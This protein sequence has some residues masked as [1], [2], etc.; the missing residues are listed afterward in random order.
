MFNKVLVANRGEI[1]L[2][3]IRSCKKLGIRSVAVYSEADARSLHVK[4]ADEAYLLGPSEAKD[5]YLN[6]AKIIEIA[7]AHQVAA[8]HPGYGFLAE[9]A[10]FA[11]ACKSAG[12][13][14][15]GP[16]PETIRLMGDKLQAKKLAHELK[17]RLVPGIT[18]ESAGMEIATSQAKLKSFAQEAGYPLILKAA[19]GGGGRGMR[20]IFNEAD[21]EHSLL[22]ASREA[23]AFFSDGRIFV[24]KLVQKARHIEVQIFG[25][26]FGAV[27]HLYDRDCS[28]QRNHQKVLEE[29]PAPNISDKTRANLYKAALSL[30]KASKYEGAGTVE[31]LLDADENFYFLEVNSRLQVE[32][33][34]T[35]ELTGLDLV[36]LQLKIAAGEKLENLIP[37]LPTNPGKTSAIELRVCSESPHQ[38][39]V[40]STGTISCLK[41]PS[42]SGVRLESGVEAEDTVTHYYDSLLAK[43][44]VRADSRKEAIELARQALNQTTIFGVSTNLS[45][46]HLLLEDSAFA[47][48]AHN[49]D[50]LPEILQGGKAFQ[51]QIACAA[52]ALAVWNMHPEFNNPWASAFGFR[53][54]GKRKHSSSFEFK[55]GDLQI[56]GVVEFDDSL[57]CAQVLDQNFRTEI[58]ANFRN[59]TIEINGKKVKIDVASYAFHAWISTDQGCFKFD[60]PTRRLRE[61]QSDMGS[62]SN[63][64]VSALPGKVI[65][66]KVETGSSISAGDALVVIE[67]MK[68]EHI[69]KAPADGMVDELC[70]TPGQVIEAGQILAKLK[71]S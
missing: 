10:E 4:T 53:L 13:I 8:I 24:E 57:I 70:C 41:F 14:F 18:L 69:L 63:E 15:I 40:A 65:A 45:L 55:L 25:D 5:S 58:A 48:A 20:R 44:V 36:E 16:T 21:I 42:L 56:E 9:N 59:G 37:E 1:A 64:I 47:N 61:H 71:F 66:L 26:K 30:A 46:L 33:P 11:E 35:E 7:S 54:D 67:S 22:G 17:I 62:H 50:R 31:F 23:Q 32:H 6:I 68:M 51:S 43:I 39:F 3:I 27:R 52:F 49:T 2:R 28:M 60:Y 34:V 38:D 19:A 29:A 12:I